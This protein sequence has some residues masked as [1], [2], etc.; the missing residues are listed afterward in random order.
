MP[1][2]GQFTNTLPEYEAGDTQEDMN[3]KALEYLKDNQRSL[4]T[5]G[6]WGGYITVG[7]DHTI[8]NVP[9]KRDFRVLG[10]A[11]YGDQNEQPYDGAAANQV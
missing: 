6:G 2:V 10:N 5:L 11:F 9:G 4:V 1:A 8:L 3:R 7:F